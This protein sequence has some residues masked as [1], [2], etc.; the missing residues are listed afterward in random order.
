MRKLSLWAKHHK[1]TARLII[2]LSFILLTLITYYSGTW[3]NDLGVM[4]PEATLLI[5][6]LFYFAG[7]IVYPHRSG[8]HK[9]ATTKSF[10]NRQDVYKRQVLSKELFTD[11][12]KAVINFSFVLSLK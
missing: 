3:L 1:Q 12:V 5:A 11:G 7:V 9:R 4:L 2:I 6:V 8:F 10:Y